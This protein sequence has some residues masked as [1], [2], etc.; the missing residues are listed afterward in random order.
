MKSD[1]SNLD[2]LEALERKL[3]DALRVV[4]L[5]K[6]TRECPPETEVEPLVYND[7]I[8]ALFVNGKGRKASET[9][10]R[11]M[12]PKDY[13]LYLDVTTGTLSFH[14]ADQQTR[15]QTVQEARISGV[16]DILGEMIAR[17]N[18]NFGNTN[19]GW[20]LPHRTKM[21]PDAFRKAMAKIRNAIQNG[22]ERGPL[23]LRFERSHYSVSESGYAWRIS[24]DLG[25][26]CFIKFLPLPPRFRR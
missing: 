15:T 24:K 5:M 9:E 11:A 14:A 22:D 6:R 3:S 25:D 4:A 8:Y 17:P 21:T 10:V 7:R 20:F 12:N 1:Y 2:L 18:L 26:L 23:L 19:I 13:A 16:E